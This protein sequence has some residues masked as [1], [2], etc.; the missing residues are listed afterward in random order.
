MGKRM[1]WPGKG[2]E[3]CTIEQEQCYKVLE[4]VPMY[5]LYM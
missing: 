2:F 1:A 4:K 3:I 5:M